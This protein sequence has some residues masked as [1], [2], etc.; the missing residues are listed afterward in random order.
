MGTAPVNPE[1]A[2][3]AVS[4]DEEIVIRTQ[5]RPGDIGA[6][7]ALHGILYAGDVGFDTTFEAYVASS[8][9][10]FFETFDAARDRFWLIE[11]DGRLLGCIAL[12]KRSP[13]DAQLRY[14][15][16]HPE[17]RGRG[18]GRRL[19]EELIAFARAQGYSRI[20]LL[21]DEEHTPAA[22]HL[23]TSYGFRR[24]GERAVDRW[25]GS[26]AEQRFDLEL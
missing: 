6:I 4:S 26:L 2:R 24:T 9:G 15:L 19:M 20:F 22:T 12:K 16:L 5:I 11:R 21:T 7:I 10:E 18:L 25:G 13:S 8:V 17:L 23:Y 3:S 1:N 14:F